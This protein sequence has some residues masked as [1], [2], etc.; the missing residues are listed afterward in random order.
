MIMSTFV[1]SVPL[2]DKRVLPFT[3]HAMSGLGRAVEVYTELAADAT[4]GEGLAVRG[5]E[6]ADAGPDLDRW[7]REVTPV[8]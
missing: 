3:T 5:E 1:E 2:D 4:I 8:A 7:L 6:V